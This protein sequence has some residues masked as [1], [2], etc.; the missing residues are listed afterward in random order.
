MEDWYAIIFLASFPAAAALGIFWGWLIW[1][2]AERKARKQLQ[3]AA[4]ESNKRWGDHLDSLD[5]R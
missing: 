5:H 1:K 2:H 4:M 3:K